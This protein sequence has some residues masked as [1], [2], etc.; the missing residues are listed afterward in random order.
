MYEKHWKDNRKTENTLFH[1]NIRNIIKEQDCYII[2]PVRSALII[3][4]I[5]NN[6]IINNLIIH[7]LNFRIFFRC[8]M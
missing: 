4:I 2:Y 8:T 6:L 3:I 7:V 5:I 1:R